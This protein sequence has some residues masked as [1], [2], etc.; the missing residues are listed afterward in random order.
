MLRSIIRRY[1]SLSSA[2]QYLTKITA[3]F[4]VVITI[5]VLITPRPKQAKYTIYSTRRAYQADTFR[6]YGRGIVFDDVNGNSVI[7]QGEIDIV[8]N[9]IK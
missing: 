5:A 9:K 6:I 3:V 8:A 1:N 4:V 2:H 7:L